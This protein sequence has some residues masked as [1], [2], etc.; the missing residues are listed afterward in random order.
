M[1]RK[2][3]LYTRIS[4]QGLECSIGDTHKDSLTQLNFEVRKAGAESVDECVEFTIVHVFL[5]YLD[6]R[7]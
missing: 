7:W 3:G 2:Q 5:L 4:I 1:I 6:V